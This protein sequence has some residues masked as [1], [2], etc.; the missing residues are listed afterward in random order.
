MKNKKSDP[1][2]A[3]DLKDKLEE[4]QQGLGRGTKNKGR[5]ED[6]P[7][8]RLKTAE[9]N[10]KNFESDEYR[11]KLQA[12]KG[13]TDAEYEK[14]LKGYEDYTKRLREEVAGGEKRAAAPPP[15]DAGRAFGS[16]N[17]GKVEP[18]TPGAGVTT[19]GGTTAAPPGF[20]KARERFKEALEKK[21]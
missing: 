5:M 1:K 6:D 14:F 16:L 19:S 8:N 3:D 13:W 2:Q 10:L 7:K 12:S 17:S 15:K 18:T 21:R 4:W 9:L 20:E 11:K